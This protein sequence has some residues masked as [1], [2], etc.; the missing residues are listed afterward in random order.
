[1]AQPLVCLLGFITAL[2]QVSTL[3]GIQ[4]ANSSGLTEHQR[5][6]PNLQ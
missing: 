6:D 4:M 1:M 5:C 3:A 2:L